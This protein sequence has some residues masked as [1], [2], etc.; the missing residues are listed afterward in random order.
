MVPAVSSMIFHFSPQ[1]CQTARRVRACLRFPAIPE[2]PTAWIKAVRV[3]RMARSRRGKRAG[4]TLVEAM[5]AVGL[6]AFAFSSL[7][8]VYSTAL[9][10]IRTQQETIHATLLLDQ[11]CAALRGANWTVLSDPARLQTLLQAVSP[12]EAH[13]PQ[14]VQE[15][16]L[17]PYAIVPP[18]VA[19][20]TLRRE[21]AALSTIVS[22]AP[23]A[24]ATASCIRVDVRLSWTGRKGNVSRGT[25]MVLAMGGTGK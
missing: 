17:R 16:S 20:L 14:L 4:A 12:A 5:L 8:V 9:G 6:M 24:L 11:R 7:F 3:V 18:V 23:A 21:Q 10:Q 19:P 1:L 2:A 13:L 25:T 15:I 22:A